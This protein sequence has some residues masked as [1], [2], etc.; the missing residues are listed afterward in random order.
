MEII[1]QRW[2]IRRNRWWLWYQNSL[3]AHLGAFILG[4]SKRKKNNILWMIDWFQDIKVFCTDMD[5]L[6]IEIKSWDVLKKSQTDWRWF[7]PE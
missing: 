2:E 4:N 7:M 3:P 6:Y 5:S 1:M